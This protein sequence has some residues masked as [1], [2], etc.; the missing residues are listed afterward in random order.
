[1]K[2]YHLAVWAQGQMEWAKNYSAYDVLAWAQQ[3]GQSISQIITFEPKPQP[4]I[5]SIKAQIVV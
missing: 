1:V 2:Y 3:L 4:V 5:Q